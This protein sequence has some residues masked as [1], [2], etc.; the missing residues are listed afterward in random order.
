MAQVMKGRMAFHG[1]TQIEM[2]DAI[3]ISQSQLSKILRADRSID[4]E[5][6][7]AFCEALGENAAD[8]VAEG[9]E[10]A[11]QTQAH[12]PDAYVPAVGLILVKNGQ[13]IKASAS[14]PAGERS[15]ALDDGPDAALSEAERAVLADA[16]AAHPEDYDLAAND[17][18]W[19]EAE[20]STPRE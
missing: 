18:P 13:R 2:A 20:G 8:L 11:K 7:E 1:I 3:G 19:K 15:P 9:E 17:D 4:L 10:I 5:A 6:F 16:I 12:N 14:A